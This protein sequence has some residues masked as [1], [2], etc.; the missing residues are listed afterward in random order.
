MCSPCGF[1]LPPTVKKLTFWV[2]LISD[3]K[4]TIGVNMRVCC[5]FLYV[6]PMMNW[7]LVQGLP[8]LRS[9]SAGTGSSVLWKCLLV[10]R[11]VKHS[12]T[13]RK[14]RGLRSSLLSTFFS[15]PTDSYF[16]RQQTGLLSREQWK[17]FTYLFVCV[18]VCL[19]AGV[20]YSSIPEKT[21]QCGSV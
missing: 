15:I 1:W 18:F 9:V 10:W 14:S 21:Q 17:A 12:A 6:S 4:L 3:S 5:L 13:K 11:K 2:R 16:F 20:M 7:E 8:C 19:F